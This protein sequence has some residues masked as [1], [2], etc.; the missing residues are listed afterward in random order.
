MSDAGPS[1]PIRR[2]P[3]SRPWLLGTAAALLAG[4]AVAGIEI[5]S[6]EDQA[7]VS[8]ADPGRILSDPAL[9]R[10][11]LAKGRVV[12]GNYCASCHGPAGKGDQAL[13]VPDLTDD[14]HLYGSGTVAETEDIVRYG[15]RAHNKRGWNLAIMP[16]YATAV[17]D[18]AEPLPPQTPLQV[19]DLTQYLLSFTG[20]ATDPGAAT[21]GHAAYEA[22]GCWDCHGH[23][24]MGEPAIGAPNLTDRIWLYG[25]SH[26]QIYRTIA[27]GRAGTSPAFIDTLSPAEIRDVAAYA[28]S[29]APMNAESR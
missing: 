10:I 12:F 25:G 26:D 14:D 20:R 4:L 22:A 19:E 3:R 8:R 7:A 17:P 11:A 15:I 6:H 16:A 21:R 28:A 9:R 27:R 1:A 29:L 24:A 13:G 23:D 2:R 5:R 18:P